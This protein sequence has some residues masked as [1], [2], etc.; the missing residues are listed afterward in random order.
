MKTIK[1]LARNWVKGATKREWPSPE[2]KIEAAYRAGYL[3]GKKDEA[4]RE[5]RCDNCGSFHHI[6]T[7]GE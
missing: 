1:Q 6:R 3:K 5:R 2:S 7:T 4:Q